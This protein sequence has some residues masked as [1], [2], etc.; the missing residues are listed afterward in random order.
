MHKRSFLMGACGAA[1]TTAAA[2]LRARDGAGDNASD[3]ASDS[4]SDSAT[5]AST[6]SAVVAAPAR[7]AAR[8]G[9][10]ALGASPDR[11]QWA[12]YLNEPFVLHAD[13]RAV[14]VVLDRLDNGPPGA[15]AR[16]FVLGFRSASALPTGLYELAHGSGQTRAIG[17]TATACAGHSA[18]R[19]RAEFNLQASANF[20]AA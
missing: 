1:L 3:H 9:L 4:A 19:L 20:E 18:S 16:Q 6:T 2:A 12:R 17:L 15:D 14:V 10:P 5:N 11:A 7:R 8:R 13:G